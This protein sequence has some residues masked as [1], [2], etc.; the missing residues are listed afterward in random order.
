M[1][2]LHHALAAAKPRHARVLLAV[3][4]CLLVVGGQAAPQANLLTLRESRGRRSPVPYD[5]AAVQFLDVSMPD[6][7]VHMPDTRT[8]PLRLNV[9]Y[10]VIRAAPVVLSSRLGTQFW[11]FYSFGAKTPLAGCA[12]AGWTRSSPWTTRCRRCWCTRT[13]RPSSPRSTTTKSS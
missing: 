7:L 12:A 11:R 5:G 1:S 2:E 9:R 8:I 4:F 13:S 6:Q 10:R 3:L